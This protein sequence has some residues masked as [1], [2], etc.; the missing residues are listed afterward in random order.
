MCEGEE[1]SWEHIWERCGVKGEEVG[2]QEA[3]EGI[4]GEEGDGEGWMRM[5]EKRRNAFEEQ[6]ENI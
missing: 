3:V 5:I 6:Y 1:E 4:L 2:W